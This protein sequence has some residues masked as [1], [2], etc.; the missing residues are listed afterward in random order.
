MAQASEVSF[1]PCGPHSSEVSTGPS[2]HKLGK[3]KPKILDYDTEAHPLKKP[4][5]DLNII[6]PKPMRRQSTEQ[7]VTRNSSIKILA[8]AKGRNLKLEG[9]RKIGADTR[10]QVMIEEKLGV[11]A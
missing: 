7:R 1:G 4:K 10:K 8:R 3:R 9:Q 6:K 11:V 5:G 2:G